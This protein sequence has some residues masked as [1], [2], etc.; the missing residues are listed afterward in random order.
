MSCM[1]H[2]PYIMLFKIKTKQKPFWLQSWENAGRKRIQQ[3]R[4][5]WKTSRLN[6][7]KPIQES[8]NT[9]IKKPTFKERLNARIRWQWL[10]VN[11]QRSQYWRVIRRWRVRKNKAKLNGS[12]TN[13]RFLTWFWD[14]FHWSCIWWK[15]K[16]RRLWNCSLRTM[17][18][19]NCCYQTNQNWNCQIRKTWRVQKR[20]RSHGSHSTS[21]YSLVLWS[22]YKATKSLY[23]SWI[24]SMRISM[25]VSSW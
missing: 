23:C 20:M 9:L 11:K 21:K 25:V 15:I 19:N 10:R 6:S 16:W 17:E 4:R 2:I 14:Q 5:S 12:E 3:R 24:L 7:W 22:L 13:K 18:G 8:R 1:W